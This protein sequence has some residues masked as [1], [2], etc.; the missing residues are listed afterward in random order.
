MVIGQVPQ[1]VLGSQVCTFC[2]TYE[3]V[4]IRIL[5][6]DLL[7]KFNWTKINA[8]IFIGI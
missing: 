7:L 2:S 6:I 8:Y 1:Y 5:L 3:N 4:M